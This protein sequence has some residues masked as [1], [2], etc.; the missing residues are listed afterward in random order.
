M[1][2]HWQRAWITG[3]SMG[4]GREMALLLAEKKVHVAL[5]ARSKD[6]L[7]A[8]AQNSDRLSAF[9]LDVTDRAAVGATVGQIEQDVGPLDLAILNAGILEFVELD[10]FD[11]SIFEQAMRVNYLGVIYALEALLPRMIERGAGHIV[12][13]GS[14]SG[15]RGM[16][17]A[18]A[19]GP[20][21]AAL[22]NLAESLKLDAEPYGIKIS[23]VNPGYVDTPMT[24]KNDFEMP[25]IISAEKAARKII[26]GLERDKF[27]IAFPVRLVRPMRMLRRLPDGLFFWIVRR[28]IAKMWE[29]PPEQK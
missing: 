28:F 10:N 25:F 24:E 12:L 19:Y 6:K 4:I 29:A 14:V 16:P 23:I 17:K 5:S 27:E 26:S 18:A 1:A 13:I 3:A 20:T 11:A 9:P 7:N 8:M 2:S 21:K 15:Y 22:I